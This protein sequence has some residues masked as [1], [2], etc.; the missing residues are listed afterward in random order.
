MKKF[1]EVVCDLLIGAVELDSFVVPEFGVSPVGLK[2]A[3]LAV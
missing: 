1:I 2:H 3:G